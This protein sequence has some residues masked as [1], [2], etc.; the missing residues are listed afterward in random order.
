M[1]AT[2]PERTVM[3]PAA[4]VPP[5]APARPPRGRGTA[6]GVAYVA[7]SA[8]S[9]GTLPVFA[10]LAYAS[11][12]DT[13]TLLLLRFTIAAALMWIVLALRGARVPRGKGLAMLVG[14]GAIGY[15]GQAFSYF[16]AVSLASAGLAALLLYLYPALVAIL[17]RVVLRHPL[18]GAQLVAIVMALL[19]SLLT[20]G[21]AVDGSPLGIFFGV[22]A[23]LIYSVYILTGGRLPAGITPTASTTV[24]SSAA[25]VV[26][27]GVVLLRGPQLPRTPVGWAAVLAIAVICTVLA[28]A[29]FLAGLE[30]LGPVRASVY[31]TLEPVT[32]LV[33][34]A[35]L[36][37]EQVTLVRA[38]GGALILGAVLLL[39]R[40]EAA[41]R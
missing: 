26:F 24:V 32:T 37:G 5:G 14:M 39:S 31:S 28:V 3:D 18:S 27:A 41:S 40:V 16:T 30:R 17:A 7:A 19:G 8:V 36:L 29:F 2:E 25:A 22:L 1:P 13:S 34:A 4:A 21:R 35:V 33:L 38:A 15:A 10:R 11:G 9:F 12:V 6:L 23:A 20:I